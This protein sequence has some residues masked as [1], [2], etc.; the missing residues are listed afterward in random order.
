[1]LLAAGLETPAC[2]DCAAGAAVQVCNAGLRHMLRGDRLRVER[3]KDELSELGN[4]FGRQGHKDGATFV[5]V[6]YK[7][8]EHELPPEHE[9]LQVCVATA[10]ATSAACS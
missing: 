7:I 6:L 2:A 4:Q 9:N 5:Y 8:A 10:G 3:F 1:M